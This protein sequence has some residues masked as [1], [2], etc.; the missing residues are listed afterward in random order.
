MA[1]LKLTVERT[2]TTGSTDLAGQRAA[3]QLRSALLHDLVTVLDL[4]VKDWGLTDDERPREEVDV[5]IAAL[6][7]AGVFTAMVTAFRIWIDRRKIKDVRIRMGKGKEIS[8]RGATADDVREIIR[9]LKLRD[10]T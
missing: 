10:D 4:K 6:G 1:T 8:I 2:M 5:V 3:A 7:S 9:A